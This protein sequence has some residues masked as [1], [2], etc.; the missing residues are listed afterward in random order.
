MDEPPTVAL[1]PTLAAPRGVVVIVDAPVAAAVG[2]RVG[3]GPALR[4]DLDAA[5]RLAAVED[6]RE[7][8]S[9]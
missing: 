9:L 1:V 8:E 6:V 5:E 2:V 7:E 3:V 4:A